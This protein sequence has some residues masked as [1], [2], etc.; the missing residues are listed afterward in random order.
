MN[1]QGYEFEGPFPLYTSSFN[2]VGAVYVISD[3][4]NSSIDVGQ[5]DNLKE[6]M[7]SHDRE[8][9]W[10]KNA[11]GK[12]VVYARVINKEED[13]LFVESKIRNA[14]KFTCGVF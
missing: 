3:D 6:R 11:T 14:H 7:S 5:T 8:D 13:R 2:G 1:I 12:I 4:K 9:C 10:V